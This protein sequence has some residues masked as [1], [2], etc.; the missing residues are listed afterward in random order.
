[1]V[2]LQQDAFDPVDASVS[3][4]RQKESLSRVHAPGQKRRVLR[5]ARIRI[6]Q[7]LQ[8]GGQASEVLARGVLAWEAVGA[9]DQIEALSASAP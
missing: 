9:G 6:V 4:D 7:V 2:Y 1:M 5:R 3:L 8:Q